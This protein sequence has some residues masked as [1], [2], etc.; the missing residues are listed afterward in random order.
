MSGR[1]LAPE[2]QVAIDWP[3]TQQHG[4]ARI[5]PKDLKP[6]L[7]ATADVL[8]GTR[9]ILTYLIKP[10]SRAFSGAMTQR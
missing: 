3:A 2:T 5:Q 10:V 1:C 6:G 7:T 4:S 9:S 8:T